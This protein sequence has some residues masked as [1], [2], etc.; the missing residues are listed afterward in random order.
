MIYLFLHLS[1][2]SQPPPE[3]MAGT[4]GRTDIETVQNHD[5]KYKH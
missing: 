4:A 2:G 3:A 5:L 1:T